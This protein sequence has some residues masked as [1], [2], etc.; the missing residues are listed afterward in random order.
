MKLEL[1]NIK[2]NM[3]F[4]EETI[5]F[6]ADLYV[7]G[8]K[9]AYASNEGRGGSTFYNRYDNKL[10]F[11]LQQAEN[12]CKSLPSKF[13]EYGSKTLEIES[14]L[15]NWIDNQIDDYVNK[16]EAL[17]FEKKMKAHMVNNIVY[18]N[19]KSYKM[20][21]WKGLTI[22]QMLA[23]PIGRQTLIN[24][25][26]DLNN[27]GETILNTNIPKELLNIFCID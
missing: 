26:S 27:K 7:D 12:Y 6:K 22:D 13:V 4:S 20:I 14:T 9:V 23:H 17:K 25:I 5:M 10:S 8:T 24:K 15:E 21:G 19:D 2:V 1:K 11:L 3:E 16:K 18:G